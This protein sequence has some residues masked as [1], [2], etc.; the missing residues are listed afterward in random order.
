VRIYKYLAQI[1][2][3]NELFLTCDEVESLHQTKLFIL[4]STVF[5]DLSQEIES[6]I[7]I[8]EIHLKDG[9]IIKCNDILGS[10]LSNRILKIIR[11]SNFIDFSSFE[12]SSIIIELFSI[13]KGT[14]ILLNNLN[15]QLL[16]DT[17]FYLE[18]E[19]EMLKDFIHFSIQD[20]TLLSDS[21]FKQFFIHL[22]CS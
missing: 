2:N 1:L 7:N 15:Q 12:Y 17:I 22:F 3:N 10:L 21:M 11:K 9:F 14:T 19:V 13:L 4:K 20:L 6:K 8:F 5:S 16:I 18:M